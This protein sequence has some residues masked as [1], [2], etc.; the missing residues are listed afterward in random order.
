M[1]PNKQK[2]SSKPFE[3]ECNELKKFLESLP[4]MES[5]YC[6]SSTQ[7]KYLLPEWRSKRALYDFYVNDWCKPNFMK[8]LTILISDCF[9]KYN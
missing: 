1:I 5:H 4:A 7:K 3:S 9:T 6:R 2:K 8:N